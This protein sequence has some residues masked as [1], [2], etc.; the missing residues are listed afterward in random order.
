MKTVKGDRSMT[1]AHFQGR[2]RKTAFGDFKNHPGRDVEMADAQLEDGMFNA[3]KAAGAITIEVIEAAAA[4][5]VI[6][7]DGSNNG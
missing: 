7:E 3:A 2:F 4:D 5:G 6:L 1:R